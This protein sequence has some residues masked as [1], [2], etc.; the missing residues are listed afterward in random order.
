MKLLRKILRKII[1]CDECKEP[2][3]PR[4]SLVLDG[5]VIGTLSVEAAK[6]DY[7]D[8]LEASVGG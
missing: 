4:V 6:A 2:C 1:G 3:A 8:N 5:T 7:F